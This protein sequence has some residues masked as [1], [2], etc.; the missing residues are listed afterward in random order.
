MNCINCQEAKCLVTPASCAETANLIIGTAT[1]DTDYWVYIWN[2]ATNRQ[3]LRPITSDNEGLIIFDMSINPA[4]FYANTQ[5]KIWVT[6]PNV[7]E[8]D[9]V[10]IEIG[11]DAYSC[12]KVSFNDVFQDGLMINPENQTLEPA[13]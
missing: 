7:N 4:F 12:F 10:D 13:I 8:S 1:P 9:T 11:E 6:L 2:E 3:I 5:F